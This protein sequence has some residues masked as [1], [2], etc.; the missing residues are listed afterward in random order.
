VAALEQPLALS[1]PTDVQVHD[2]LASDRR[3]WVR[4]R[5][6]IACPAEPPSASWWQVWRRPLP[7]ASTEIDPVQLQ[8]EVGGET[9]RAQVPLDSS[10]EFE[11]CFEAALPQARRGWRVARHHITVGEETHRACSVVLTVPAEARSGLVVVL[12]LEFTREP[13]AVQRWPLSRPA[14][15]LSRLFQSWQKSNLGHCPV[16]YLACVPPGDSSRQAEM[17]LAAASLGWPSGHFLLL[18][19]VPED[20][21][22]VFAHAVDRLRW[23]L[24]GRLELT[25]FNQEPGA[26]FALKAAVTPG[27]DRAAVR[28]LVAV[29][30]DLDGQESLSR[31]RPS[32]LL[33]RGRPTR[34]RSLPRH[35]LVFCHG[36]LAMTMLRMQVPEDCNYFCH[37]RPFLQERGVYALYPNVEPTGGV[38]ERAEQLRDQIRRWTDEPVHIIGHSMGGLDARYMITHL[39]MADRVCSLTTLATPH[40]GTTLADWFCENYNE[41]VPLLLTLQAFGVNVDGF[42]DCRPAVCRAFNER[43]PDVPRVRYFSYSASVTPTRVSPLLRRSWFLVMQKEGANDGM[44]SVASARWGEHLGTLAVDHFAQTPDGLFLRSGESFDP[45][46]FCT[47]LIEHLAHRG[48]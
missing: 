34:L 39:D 45:V 35:P 9:L 29:E 43:T 10:G 38:A 5:V 7:P 6:R 28:R 22:K 4:G 27:E 44:V 13:D 11:T 21:A 23:L 26:E 46:G 47:R 37:L 12:P 25:V 20:A 30:Q 2:T 14:A 17:A 15:R 41:R 18:P 32:G 33:L 42:R 36:M 19:S 3:L 24:A 1:L 48:L 16:Y 31:M 8:T 40:R